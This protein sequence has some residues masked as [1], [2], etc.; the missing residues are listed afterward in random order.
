MVLELSIPPDPRDRGD[1]GK[2]SVLAEDDVPK[3]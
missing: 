3:S 2:V 1:C